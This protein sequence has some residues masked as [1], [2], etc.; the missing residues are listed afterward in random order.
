MTV[1]KQT[2]D[3]VLGDAHRHAIPN[4][5]QTDRNNVPLWNKPRNF[6][7]SMKIKYNLNE[8]KLL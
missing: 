2:T 5:W 4:V 7:P 1:E 8:E 6:K 3:R